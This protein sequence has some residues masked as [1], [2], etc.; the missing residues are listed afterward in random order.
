M[1]LGIEVGLDP[2]HIM[3]DGDPAPLPKKVLTVTAELLFCISTYWL[4][5]DSHVKMC[6][7]RLHSSK[8]S[9]R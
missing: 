1:A 7:V 5:H 3:Q 2:G 9:N 6:R 8:A 4:T